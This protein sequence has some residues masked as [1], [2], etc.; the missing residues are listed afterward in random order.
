MGL[1]LG[2]F[3]SDGT[4]WRPLEFRS[5]EPLHV[6][7]EAALYELKAETPC[8]NVS[9]EWTDVGSVLSTG[10]WLATFPPIGSIAIETEAEGESCGPTVRAAELLG[11]GLA[12]S[13]STTRT[14]TGADSVAEFT[15]GP[16]LRPL[17]RLALACVPR[18]ARARLQPGGA[19]ATVKMCGQKPPPLFN[20]DST[21]ALIRPDF[22]TEAYFGAGWHDAERT[23]TG[24]TRRGDAN[25]TLLLPLSPDFSYD[26]AIDVVAGGRIEAALNGV[27]LTSC[28]S[29]R[30]PLCNMTL[31]AASIRP[32]VNAVTLSVAEP[33]TADTSRTPLIFRGARLVR[34]PM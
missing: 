34:K 10:S 29:G 18:Q 21:H 25:A 31:P 27:P 30:G 19:A 2:V 5:G 13:V 6:T 14:A 8:V 32:G 20:G 16:I 4:L 12:R 1:A 9:T 11:G 33:T 28:D 3:R 22:E 15:R 24:R 17:F 26:M 23:P 7:P